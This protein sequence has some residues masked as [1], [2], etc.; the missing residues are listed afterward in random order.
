MNVALLSPR[1]WPEVRRGTERFAHELARGLQVAGHAPTI[2]T[3]SPGDAVQD[4][5]TVRRVRR[6]PE[7][8]L[9]RRGFERH[10][11][12][13][14]FAVRATRALAPDV[15]HALYPADAAGAAR[16]GRPLVHSY[17]GIPHRT[18]LVA[19]RERLRITHEA[20][21]AADATVVLSTTARD[22]FARW[23]GVEARVIAPGV[24]L[25]VFTPDPA[26]RAEQ[27]TILCAADPGEPRKR[28][29]LLIEAF[30]LVRRERP[31]ARLIL[32]KRA[33]QAEGVERRDL[34]DRAALAGANR[35]A[36]VCALPS[37]GEAFG[38]VLLEAMACGTPVVGS[39]REAIPEVIA[40]DAVGRLFDGDDPAALARALLEALE[41][42]ED[43]ATSTACRA[44]AERYSWEATT[45]AY[46]D[47]YEELT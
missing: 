1:F 29:G 25:D 13:V 40:S 26:A 17:M 22:A 19:R 36:W 18:A 6:L 47:I 5:V 27:P 30:A 24:D 46:L 41:L 44:H 4:G 20:V 28:V 12:H 33:A 39:N 38:L 3:A 14:P 11:T 43:P 45:R 31:T 21:R 35:E 7:D 2:V 32:D 10:L 23:L 8:R 15:V 34:D 16:L 42:A 37:W 9:E